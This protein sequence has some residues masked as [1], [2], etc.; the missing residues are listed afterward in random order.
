MVNLCTHHVPDPPRPANPAIHDSVLPSSF[1]SGAPSMTI[2]SVGSNCALFAR[3]SLQHWPLRVCGCL[4]S[5][6]IA[7]C[8][9]NLQRLRAAEPGKSN[10]NTGERIQALT[11]K[12]EA[13]VVDGMKAFD[14]PGVAIG[15]I[16]GNELVYSKGWGVRSK[17]GGVPVDPQTLFQIGSTTKAFLSTT[18]AIAVDRGKFHWDDRVVDLEPGFQLKDPW[19]TREFRVFDL[20]AQRSGL[21]PYANDALGSL[22]FD[23]NS[24]IRSLRYVEPISSFRSSF[25]Y[26]NI[27]H[28]I[29][30][31][32]VA[33]AERAANW[34]AVLQ[35]ELLGPLGM[36]SSTY[37]AVAI[38]AAANHAEGHRYAPDASVQVPFD[39]FFPYA[40]GGAGD[41]N[42]NVEEMARWVRLQLN[43]GSF[44]GKLIVSPENL[45]VTRTPKVA[46]NDKM[47]YALGW[48]TAQTPNGTVVWHNGGTPGFGAFVGLEL[49]RHIGVVILTN[50]GNVGFPDALGIWIFDRLLNNVSLDH[51][52][53]TLERAK[54]NF[55]RADNMFARPAVTRASPPLAPLCG[56]FANP[57]FGKVTL[58]Q[59]NGALIA[60]LQTGAR[61]KLEPW[62]GEIFTARLLAEGRFL[63]G[64]QGQGPR[65]AGFVQF[66]MDRDGKLNV[67]R[68]S[69]DDGQG[70]DFRR[71]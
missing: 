62:D 5:A 58:K 17:S 54:T 20:L 3:S 45:A 59:D 47:S 2:S 63:T 11:P 70:Y 6:V 10:Q 29:A 64:A 15:I 26:T 43:N 60:V 35:E 68:L 42:S 56:S 48:I 69:F 1:A 16:A 25:A 31:R 18:M 57:N 24:L 55:A 40:F 50:Q 33:N 13:Y 67:L 44:E 21:P 22:G 38:E 61:L 37:T 30:G 19:V 36:K 51:I 49:D 71:L 28:M 66:Q 65:P 12:L 53:A 39:A 46:L 34:N 9:V 7:V 14:V 32:I 23:E 8:L 41:I 4:L 27:T 52:A